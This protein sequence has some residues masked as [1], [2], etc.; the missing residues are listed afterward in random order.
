MKISHQM[1]VS[2]RIKKGLTDKGITTRS[3]VAFVVFG[4]IVLVFV[5]TDM[6]GRQKGSSTMGVAADVNGEL[7]SL[8]DFQ[9]EENRLAQYYSQFFGGQM[10]SELQRSMLRGEVMN[11]LVTKSVASQ[12]AEKEGIYATDAEIR[13]MIVQELP[14]FK[15]DG[16]FQSDLYKGLLQA[17]KMTPSEFE[18]KLRQDIKNQRSRLLFES[19]LTMSELQKTAENELRAAKINLSFIQL[20]ANDY[21]KTNTVS[22]DEANKALASVEFKKK[23]EDN[24]KTNQAKYDT[25]EQVRAA[26]ILIKSESDDAGAR[27]KADSVSKRLQKE[28]FNAVASQVS[29]D[30]GTKK[31]GGEL[32][33]FSKGQMVKEFEEAAFNM[34]V[35]QISDPVKS[36]FGY[37][38]IKVLEKRPAHKADFESVKMEI[39][40][41]LLADEKYIAFAS[42][43]EKNLSAGKS[44]MAINQLADAKLTWKDTGHFDISTDTVPIINS[45]QAIKLAM[46]LSMAQP[47]AKKL[48]REGDKQYLIKLKDI[49]TDASI[50]NIKDQSLIER[51][52]TTGVF[53]AWVDSFKKSARI[54]VNTGLTQPAQ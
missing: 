48:V 36:A 31:K 54:E 34:K 6:T 9:D 32:G 13:H 26:H 17:N 10:D 46:G 39:A 47:V 15:K 35:G 23:V 44:E 30:P 37:H 22:I 28:N 38:I 1:S 18:G 40:Q 14:Y 45:S 7:I 16:N 11:S 21:A 12:A 25:A 5:L 43:I 20:S 41:K 27:K 52:K 51:Q 29:D 8:K 33:F 19:A 2:S 50:M 49:K 42:D 4:M 53:Q 3:I 24:F